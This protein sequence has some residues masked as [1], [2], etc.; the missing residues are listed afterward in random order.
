MYKN[1]LTILKISNNKITSFD[2]VKCLSEL[3]Q[4][5][6]LDIS[7]NELC[8]SESYRDEIFKLLPNLIALDGQ[9]QEGKSV[10][11][12]EDDELDEEGEFDMEGMFD[13]EMLEKLDPEMRK[14]VE[15]GE[16]GYED[17]KALGVIPADD[18]YGDEEFGEEGEEEKSE[19]INGG[20]EGGDK[21]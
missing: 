19:N 4:L 6:K 8:K 16:L 9:D 21:K 2:Q 1:T 10:Y 18:D 5:I 15:S 17:L 7:E 12:E 11:S 3:E 20:E 14:K 13:E